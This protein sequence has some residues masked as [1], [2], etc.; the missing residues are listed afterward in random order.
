MATARFHALISG[1]VQMVG[2]RMFAQ[3]W[4]YQV[5]VVGYV[6]NMPDGSVEV[7]AEG[8]QETLEIFLERLK[9]GPRSARIDNLAADWQSSRGEF[10]DFRISY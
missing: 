6:R 1:R 3:D 4:A 7:V 5:G 8:A 9:Q 2:F 10:T